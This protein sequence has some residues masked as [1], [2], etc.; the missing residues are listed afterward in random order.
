MNTV[1]YA[2]IQ[3]A[4]GISARP[5][6]LPAFVQPVTRLERIDNTLAVPPSM[7]PAPDD[8]LGH[9]LFALKH[10][11][12]HL[13]ILAQALPQIPVEAFENVLR[14]SPNGIY[15]RKACYLREAFSSEPITQHAP[16]RGSFVALFDPERYITRD[17]TR[18]SRWRVEFNGL[19]SLAYCATVDRTAELESLLSHDILGR[20]RAF[21]D[22]LPKMMMDRAINWAYLSETQDSFAIEREAPSADKAHR[23]IELLRQA[24]ERHPLS[25]N[26]LVSLQNATVSNPLD[27]AAAYRH[28]Q[29]YLAGALPGAAGVTYVPPEPELCRELMEELVQFANQAPGQID[30]LIAAGIISFGF[31]FL[32]PFMDGNGRLSRFLIHQ[33][34]CRAGALEHGLL[35][36]VSVAMKRDEGRYLETLQVFSKPARELWEVLWIDY[37]NLTFEFTGHPAIYRY[38]DATPAVTFTLE[39]AQ[40]ALEIELQQETLFLQC[41]DRIVAA[42]DENYD[43][44]GSD[45]ANLVMMCLTNDGVMSKNRRKQYQ[46][47]VTEE[48]FDF[49]EQ[50]A[51]ALLKANTP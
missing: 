38:W 41:F 11:G 40:R 35:L 18:N 49:I 37:G 7:A 20:A 32:H 22:S 4:L 33:T 17:G 23:F 27:K 12:I 26:Y 46:Y 45:L 51:Q 31:V 50:Q 25:E 48:V 42:V 5:L 21:I 43:V 34:L 1:G 28:E 47:T 14:G 39:M 16:V 2:F 3:E 29:N 10:E 13:G 24:H 36:P 8:V 9:V 19:G 44:R 30:P 6:R 15:I